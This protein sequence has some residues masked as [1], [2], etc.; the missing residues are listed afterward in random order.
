[1]G[2]RGQQ[3]CRL[4]QVLI[5]H[6]EKER[7]R[8]SWVYAGGRPVVC[9]RY[10]E[11]RREEVIEGFMDEIGRWKTCHLFQYS[12]TVIVVIFFV[13]CVLVPRGRE[14]DSL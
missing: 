11:T 9:I 4:Y 5:D 12:E 1:M 3:A 8:D 13:S 14:T 7:L 10:P 2:L 6:V